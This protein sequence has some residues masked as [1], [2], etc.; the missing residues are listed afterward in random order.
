MH[1]KKHGYART[2]TPRFEIH[3]DSLHVVP[4]PNDIWVILSFFYASVLYHAKQC[5]YMFRK[6]LNINTGSKFKNTNVCQYAYVCIQPTCKPTPTPD[7]NY[8]MQKSNCIMYLKTTSLFNDDKLQ[9]RPHYIFN[10][11]LNTTSLFNNNTLQS[12][13]PKIFNYVTF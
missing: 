7:V 8:N 10:Y 11:V 3:I 5:Q 4:N 9:S 13:L 2:Y 6:D 1:T 12:C